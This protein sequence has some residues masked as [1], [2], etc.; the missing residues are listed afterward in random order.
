MESDWVYKTHLNAGPMSSSRWPM[1]SKLHDSFVDFLNHVVL[2]GIYWSFVCVFWF[3]ILCF[4]GFV[5][6]YMCAS[7][8]L[9][10][11]NYYYY[12]CLLFIFAFCLVKRKILQWFGWVHGGEHLGRDE[13]EKLWSEYVVRIF[14]KNAW[15]FLKVC[16]LATISI[17]SVKYMFPNI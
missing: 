4:S 12:Y 2:F 5:S 13:K 17:I 16:V 14:I 9:G 6:V 8:A 15:K 7:C 1:P 11:F 10:C 3:L